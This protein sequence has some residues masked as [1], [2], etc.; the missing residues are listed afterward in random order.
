MVSLWRLGFALGCVQVLDPV[1][2]FVCRL[3]FRSGCE[4]NYSFPFICPLGLALL[5]SQLPFGGEKTE[6]IITEMFAMSF[7]DEFKFKFRFRFSSYGS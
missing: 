1:L 7:L 4:P 5:G 2:V 3:R 6:R